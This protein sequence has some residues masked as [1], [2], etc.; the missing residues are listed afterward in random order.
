MPRSWRVGARGRVSSGYPY[1][2]VINKVYDLGSRSFVPVYGD[3]DSARLPVFWS[4]DV[5]VDKTF[6]F[7]RWQLTAYLDLSSPTAAQQ[8]AALKLVVRAVRRLIIDQYG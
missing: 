2:P 8:K 4:L 6:T 7:K 5:R 1:T 3:A